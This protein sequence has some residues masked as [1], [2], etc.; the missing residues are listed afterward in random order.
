MYPVLSGIPVIWQY[1]CD[2]PWIPSFYGIGKKK[3]FHQIFIYRICQSLKYKYILFFYVLQYPHTA[4]AIREACNFKLT[5]RNIKYFGN[6][7]KKWRIR[8]SSKNYRLH[9]HILW[10]FFPTFATKMVKII[11]MADRML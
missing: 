2:F 3:K 10:Y 7:F 1:R 8:G 11:K 6:F 9:Y 4:L 5:N